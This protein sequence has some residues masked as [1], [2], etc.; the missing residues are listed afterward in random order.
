MSLLGFLSAGIRRQV[1]G[2]RK[3]VMTGRPETLKTGHLTLKPCGGA[4]GFRRHSE[5]RRFMAEMK[6]IAQVLA[7]ERLAA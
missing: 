6:K 7:Q 1:T 4:P 5:I 2:I 3:T